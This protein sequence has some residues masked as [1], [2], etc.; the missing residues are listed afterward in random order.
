MKFMDKV[1]NKATEAGVAVGNKAGELST[2]SEIHKHE[3]GIEEDYKKI[4][5]IVYENS[6]YNGTKEYTEYLE[7]INNHKSEIAKLQEKLNKNEKTATENEQ[8]F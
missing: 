6:Y 5:E 1:I 8:S 3:L 2:K 7:S 4:G